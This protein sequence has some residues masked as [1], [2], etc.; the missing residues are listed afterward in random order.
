MPT[1]FSFDI[2]LIDETG[3][4][5]AIW[6]NIKDQ[7]NLYFINLYLKDLSSTK[8]LSSINI[9]LTSDEENKFLTFFIFK[10]NNFNEL[11]GQMKERLL[12][13][14]QSDKDI[15]PIML[16]DIEN[17]D[18][19]L[20]SSAKLLEKVKV[21]LKNNSIKLLPI[22]TNYIK[23]TEVVND[24]FKELR[25]KVSLEMNKRFT[26]YSTNIEKMKLIKQE[27]KENTY[28]YI[29]YKESLIELCQLAEFDSEIIKLSESDVNND[30]KFFD[31]FKQKNSNPYLTDS[32]SIID[33]DDT[34]I[35]QKIKERNLTN[36]DYQL[37][38]FNIIIR[39]NKNLRD[40]KKLYLFVD[41]FLHNLNSL[42]DNFPNHYYFN[43]WSMN[44][45]LKII[46]FYKM[47]KSYYLNPFEEKLNKRAQ[48]N[49]INLHKKTLRIFAK[50]L[51]YEIPTA[52][53]FRIL[54]EDKENEINN[55]N[56]N[57]TEGKEKEIKEELNIASAESILD[58]KLKLELG[59]IYKNKNSG[60][61]SLFVKDI[62]KNLDDKLKGL[63]SSKEKL[64]EEFLHVLN[65]LENLHLD[66]KERKMALKIQMEK[67]PLLFALG[68]FQDLKLILVDLIRI[69]KYKQIKNTQKDIDNYSENYNSVNNSPVKAPVAV[70]KTLN[71]FKTQETIIYT[72]NLTINKD[73]NI[74][75]EQKREIELANIINKWPLLKEYLCSLLILLLNSLEKSTENIR[76]I[77]ET[78]NVYQTNDTISNYLDL[79]DQKIIKNI[80]IKY[81]DD[82]ISATNFNNSNNSI[83][84]FSV[85]GDREFFG[86]LLKIN[87][88]EI[89]EFKYYVN[90]SCNNINNILNDNNKNKDSN[91]IY[92]FN[93]EN[94]NTINLNFEIKN[95]TDLEM[96]ITSISIDFW[97]E[98]NSQKLKYDHLQLNSNSNSS[99]DNINVNN[100]SENN[101][102]NYF[103]IK[104]SEISEFKFDLDIKNILDNKSAN[105]SSLVIDKIYFHLT[106]GVLGIY[107]YKNPEFMIY[108][109]KNEIEV[110]TYLNSFMQK[111]K[112]L[113]NLS[114]AF[115]NEKENNTNTNF[116]TIFF[117]VENPLTLKFSNFQDIDFNKYYLDVDFKLE[118]I[119]ADKI[120]NKNNKAILIDNDGNIKMEILNEIDFCKK[121]IKE[122]QRNFGFIITNTNE[123]EENGNDILEEDDLLCESEK[124]LKSK[125]LKLFYNNNE[126]KIK[127]IS[128]INSQLEN[129]EDLFNKFINF[130]NKLNLINYYCNNN[131]N[132]EGLCFLTLKLLFSNSDFYNVYKQNL[133]IMINIRDIK[134]NKSIFFS[135][136]N[137]A[138]ELKHLF[139]F[140]SK[141]IIRNNIRLQENSNSTNKYKS[142]VN[143]DKSK[144]DK[145]FFLLQNSISLNLE[146]DDIFIKFNK[147]FSQLTINKTLE[148]IEKIQY[149]FEEFNKDL[150]ESE[151]ESDAFNLMKQ[152]LNKKQKYKF[153][154]DNL[155]FYFRIKNKNQQKKDKEIIDT[156]DNE[157]SVNENKSFNSSDNDDNNNEDNDKE[158]DYNI[159]NSLYD[160]EFNEKENENFKIST[161]SFKFIF[162]IEYIYE[163]I[164]KLK[165]IDYI[166]NVRIC[167]DKML[168][169][170]FKKN[171][172]IIKEKENEEKENIESKI[173]I[174]KKR[175]LSVLFDN[176]NKKSFLNKKSVFFNNFNDRESSMIPLSNND[177]DNNKPKINLNQYQMSVNECDYLE[178]Y[179]EISIVLNV[180]KINAKETFFMI[181]VCEDNNWTN[182]GKNKIIDSFSKNE[183]EKNVLIKLLPLQDGYLKLPEFEF[184]EISANEDLDNTEEELINRKMDINHLDFIG[185][186]K[187]S[188][189]SITGN[190]KTLKI[191]P[192][193]QFGVKLTII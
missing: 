117:N 115:I 160:I 144:L 39:S 79:K 126:E 102:Q 104:S 154:F 140:S 59:N 192:I 145:Y 184:F 83:S 91:K 116:N 78:L 178:I 15:F 28:T 63:I 52:K 166:I 19:S 22:N 7:L 148:L 177:N 32:F 100:I 51:N 37:H 29:F 53:L 56:S 96:K 77:I 131:S 142:K 23:L 159:C 20:K 111:N 68:K 141:A 65:N 173:N 175:N 42:K 110:N 36:L 161:D 6:N 62:N 182:I 33:F 84:G 50:S 147:E 64:F 58:K 9:N 189:I 155:K 156:D 112:N 181:R 120:D 107:K 71:E 164:I 113:Q 93:Q 13:V 34:L 48:I 188:N 139:S 180:K 70:S 94:T 72:Q 98:V 43:M 122:N 132:N 12:K 46:P 87:L 114:N 92:F 191:N 86:N 18:S 193:N 138:I 121:S 183:K 85:G 163:K 179:K 41:K 11:K 136:E 149:N 150:Y 133:N 105:V 2:K 8:A 24:F 190:M 17:S 54:G 137:Y 146:I 45:S 118:K 129:D 81:L 69:C 174:G 47:L 31:S 186:G 158:K 5:P 4:M 35:K 187:N 3:I 124:S 88:N 176:N 40:F 21:E 134:S 27:S 75:N 55:F 153:L 125:S 26:F 130:E 66:L 89:I 185:L 127:S 170:L 101:E 57:N 25:N 61:Y 10:L 168:E 14:L 95:N 151:F 99:I 123:K 60:E 165:K 108:V 97:D 152:N 76:I 74:T 16:M 172:N 67:L 106:W 167:D 171:I 169:K 103:L 1:K 128:N 135:K 157:N 73:N 162:P 119:C 82:H 38:L 44:F 49:L 109:K 30:Y 90:S 80:L 143:S